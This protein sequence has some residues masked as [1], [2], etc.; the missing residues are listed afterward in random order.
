MRLAHL[1]KERGT[2]GLKVE[3]LSYVPYHHGCTCVSVPV[4][5]VD[6]HMCAGNST[7]KKQQCNGWVDEP[8]GA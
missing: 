7:M 8:L 4:S 6:I 2:M 3:L 5:Y 1:E